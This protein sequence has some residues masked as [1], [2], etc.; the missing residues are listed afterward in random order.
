MKDVQRLDRRRNVGG[1]GGDIGGD[2]VVEDDDDEDVEEENNDEDDEESAMTGIL[3]PVR[4]TLCSGRRFV[5]V[6][7]GIYVGNNVCV[8]GIRCKPRRL[9][10]RRERIK[11]HGRQGSFRRGQR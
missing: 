2:A 8:G 4:L 6:G 11:E 9:Q 1:G 5:G 3:M 7:K 10:R